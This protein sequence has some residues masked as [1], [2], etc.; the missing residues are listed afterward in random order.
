MGKT[1]AD[2]KCMLSKH[3][4][5]VDNDY[6]DY[7]SDDSSVSH[8]QNI[9]TFVNQ[10]NRSNIADS[11]ANHNGRTENNNS[12]ISDSCDISCDNSCD[13]V[14]YTSN[15]KNSVEHRDVLG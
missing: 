14:E 6:R 12:S 8:N 2:H 15:G 5:E 10:F 4:C 7:D 9:S 13:S 3:R 1:W 11:C